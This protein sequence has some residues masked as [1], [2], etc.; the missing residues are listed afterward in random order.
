MGQ[1]S[2]WCSAIRGA[3]VSTPAL[4]LSEKAPCVKFL[5]ATRIQR[6]I[7]VS[8]RFANKH[9]ELMIILREACELPGSLWALHNQVEVEVF[10]AE[11]TRACRSH[12]QAYYLAL[13]AS[14]ETQDTHPRV[15]VTCM[16]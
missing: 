5:A 7:F 14:G 2:T 12:R 16:A 6:N 4:L 11:F 8:D 13:L 1:R 10:S 15:A 3:W 9:G